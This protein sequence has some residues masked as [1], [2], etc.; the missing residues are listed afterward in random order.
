MRLVGTFIEPPTTLLYAS[1]YS[2]GFATFFYN[3]WFPMDLLAA[4]GILQ[5]TSL[6]MTGNTAHAFLARSGTMSRDDYM[7]RCK[8]QAYL[9]ILE[10]DT[11]LCAS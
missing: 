8:S 2:C 10:G 6:A 11:A 1:L 7:K 5:V 9:H 4:N 3:V